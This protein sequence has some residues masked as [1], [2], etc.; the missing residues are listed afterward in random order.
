MNLGVINANLMPGLALAES[1]HHIV[2][3]NGSIVGF[4]CN[5]HE[6]IK[7][8]KLLRRNGYINPYI[9]IYVKESEKSILVASDG[10]RLC[11]PYLIVENGRKLITDSH[12]EKIRC[13]ELTFD[14][15]VT[16]GIAEFMDVNEQNNSLIAMYENEITDEHTHLEIDPMTILGVCVALVPYP[17]HNQSPRNTYQCAMGK[18]AMGKF[19]ILF[20]FILSLNTDITCFAAI[21]LK[22]KIMHDLILLN[23]P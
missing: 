17:H 23:C 5:H 21:Y 19:E 16:Q 6:F 1:N 13:S 22:A 18:Q 10:G 14:D 20:K 9:S 7:S 15:L 3:L 4:C 12:V 11:R 2:L 8:F